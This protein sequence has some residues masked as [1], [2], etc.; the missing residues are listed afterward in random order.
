[1]SSFS[2][3][4]TTLLNEPLLG[5]KND[6]FHMIRLQDQSIDLQNSW[7]TFASLLEVFEEKC[8]QY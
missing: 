5:I 6:M 1:M 7:S 2:H 4:S 3:I 8:N